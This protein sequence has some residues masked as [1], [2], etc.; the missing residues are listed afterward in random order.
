MM[1]KGILMPGHM[2]DDG[3]H[4]ENNGPKHNLFWDYASVAE[5]IGVYTAHDY[6]DIVDHLVRP[7]LGK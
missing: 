1:H 7:G 4:T 3:V 5:R 6:A 2:A